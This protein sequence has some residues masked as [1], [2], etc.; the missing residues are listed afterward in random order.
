MSR[1]GAGV[2]Y[3]ARVVSEP[4]ERVQAVID[5]KLDRFAP[6]PIPGPTHVRKPAA[7]GALVP[8]SRP[9]PKLAD[10]M[11]DDERIIVLTSHGISAAKIR[12]YLRRP[13]E[14]RVIQRRAAKK[15]GPQ[16]TGRTSTEVTWIASWM[17]PI[18]H[19]LLAELGKDRYRCD[20]CA[21]PVP[22]G[23]SIHHTRYE[24]STIY[25][26]MYVCRSCNLARENKG[27]T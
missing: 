16:R 22:G 13:I 23:C 7:R 15:L 8:V 27:L 12:P 2:E 14:T 18:I 3:I 17:F 1:S 20:L 6:A 19:P 4:V 26:L 24:G 5:G 11:T 10:D 9:F 21:E 25:D